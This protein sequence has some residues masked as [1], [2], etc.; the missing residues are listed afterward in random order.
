[1]PL[2]KIQEIQMSTVNTDLEIL[3][4]LPRDIS[5]GKIWETTGNK[6][7]RLIYLS[8]FPCPNVVPLKYDCLLFWLVFA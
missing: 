7:G 1:M 4:L 2:T 5:V 8:N 6:N 3:Y